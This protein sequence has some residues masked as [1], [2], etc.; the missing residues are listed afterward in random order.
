MKFLSQK[1]IK[2]R[3]I[4]W[5]I[6]GVAVFLILNLTF[7][8]FDKLS[9][10]NLIITPKLN[11]YLKFSYLLFS[12]FIAAK[13]KLPDTRLSK[14]FIYLP[15]IFF[16]VYFVKSYIIGQVPAI[17]RNFFLFALLP[18]FIIIKSNNDNNAWRLIFTIL[19]S[20]LILNFAIILIGII[21][22]I[23]LFKSYY[24]RFGYNGIMLNQVQSSYFYIS[25]VALFYYKRNYKI[26]I[27]CLLSGFLL[28]TK[29]FILGFFLFSIFIIFLSKKISFRAKVIWIVFCLALVVLSLNLIFSTDIFK[30]V[31]Q[32]NNFLTAFFSYRDQLFIEFYNKIDSSNFNVFFGVNKM[33]YYRSEL[34]FFDVF[35]FLGVLGLMFYIFML[36]KIFRFLA[37]NS[38]S[39]SY[40]I[41]IMFMVFFGGNFFSFPFNCFVF[42]FV[43]TYI[44]HTQLAEK[45]PKKTELSK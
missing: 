44:G 5:I 39:V 19:K 38:I 20:F 45:T 36:V 7:D 6:Y 1:T 24:G 40:F 9:A 37:S 25:M 30:G 41:A 26:V 22:D 34:G 32:K 35:L 15:L 3:Q 13:Y 12:L 27:I 10:H 29:A 28:G 4:S 18:S 42:L 31:I 14:Y 33:K 16:I 8:F 43:L 23:Q 17:F 2:N 11:K 21:W